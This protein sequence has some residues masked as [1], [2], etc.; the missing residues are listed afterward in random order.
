VNGTTEIRWHARAG[1]G[2]KTA[3]QILAL[4]LLR[5]G[6]GVQAFPE[7][8]PE[9]RG[10]PLRAFTRV[11]DRPIRRHDTVTDP[12]VVVVLEPSLIR[13]AG[14]E[15]GLTSD[16]FVLFNGEEAPPE[17]DGIDVR[18]VP[19]QRLASTLGSGF[20]NMVMLGAVAAELGEP[21]LADLQEAAV[22]TLG[23][24]VEE[25]D[26]RRALSEGYAWVS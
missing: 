10:A 25:D 17:L 16:G 19:A 1:Q 26:V 5:T 18:C 24:K 11:A 6:K 7:Y 22:E 8:G 13:E 21:P 23:R 9:R 12:D 15:E 2:A 20:V 4:A 14:V 3:A